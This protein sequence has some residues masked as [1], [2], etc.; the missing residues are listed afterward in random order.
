MT[1]Y[2][3]HDIQIALFIAKKVIILAE[4]PYL[5]NMVSKKSAKLLLKNS[6]KLGENE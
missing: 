3:A 5:A 1:I 2:L 6:I 4:Y